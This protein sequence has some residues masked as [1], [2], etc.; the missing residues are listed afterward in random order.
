MPG[1]LEV[2]ESGGE[3][4]AALTG[5]SQGSIIPA[6][7][8]TVY[9]PVPYF[10]NLG[11]LIGVSAGGRISTAASPGTLTLSLKLGSVLVWSAVTATLAANLTNKTWWLDLMLR[12]SAIGPSATLIGIAKLYCD[13]L[14]ASK[15]VLLLPDTAPAA[16]SA[17]DATQAQQLDLVG[18]FSLTGNSLTTHVY[19]PK[20]FAK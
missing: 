4:S 20:F 15:Q 6:S 13:G 12:L 11:E 8:K 19:Y 9:T 10:S 1:F 18:Q 17:F 5:T 3:D 2:P 7:R 14:I 16:G